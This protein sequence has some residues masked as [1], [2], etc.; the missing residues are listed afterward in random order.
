MLKTVLLTVSIT[1][2]TVLLLFKLFTAPILAMA[3]LGY[4]SLE[5]L[6]TLQVGNTA[7]REMQRRNDKRRQDAGK[8]F[9]RKA[10]KKLAV[11]ALAAAT[12]GTPAVALAT[13]KLE[14]DDEC[15]R[16]EQLHADADLLFGT[17]TD[18]DTELCLDELKTEAQ[19]NFTVLQNQAYLQA[20]QWWQQEQWLTAEQ[21]R[22]LFESLESL[23]DAGKTQ[24]T[25]I[26]DELLQM[27]EA[28][29]DNHG[30]STPS[31]Q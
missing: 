23:Q 5:T 7:L 28:L 2:A 19:D 1:L 14:V 24:Q 11:S 13:I 31:A 10:Q 16:R 27:F 12:I 3:G 25:A 8:R 30:N 18:F 6:Q 4:T 15:E 17:S 9:T 29:K 21:K 22:K 26:V 20:Y